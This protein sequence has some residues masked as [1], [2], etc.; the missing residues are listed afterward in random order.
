MSFATR[1]CTVC[2]WKDQQPNMVHKNVTVKV[3][4]S[5]NKATVMTWLGMMSGNKVA[6]NAVSRSI[7][8]AG[9]RTYYRNQKKWMCKTCANNHKDIKRTQE[10]GF[11]GWV[12]R[13]F[14]FI[15]LAP[16]ILGF[17]SGLFGIE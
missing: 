14:I 6:E 1:T 10:I 11:F 2:G 5:K 16:L 4:K 7:F 17:L 8:N 3:G 12:Q 13:I 15:L 9:Q